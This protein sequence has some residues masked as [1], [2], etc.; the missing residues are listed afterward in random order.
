MAVTLNQRIIATGR[1]VRC[2][3]DAE[4]FG[5]RTTDVDVGDLVYVQSPVALFAVI[6]V[7]NLRNT[8]GYRPIPLLPDLHLP[9]DPT[10]ADLLAAI[11]PEQGVATNDRVLTSISGVAEWRVVNATGIGASQAETDAG[12]N[13]T[14]FV[15][16]KT[17]HGYV[18]PA[19]AAKSPSAYVQSDGA[20]SNRASSIAV[21]GARGNL[22]GFP[23]P[24]TAWALVQ[25][26]AGG[27]YSYLSAQSNALDPLNPSVT[28]NVFVIGVSSNDILIRARGAGSTDTRDFRYTGG[29]TAYEGRLVL[30]EAVWASGDTSADPQIFADGADITASFVASVGAGTPPNWFD[31]GLVGTNHILGQSHP[32]GRAPLGAFGFGAFSAAERAEFVRTGLPPAWWMRGG[33]AVQRITGTDNADFNGGTTGNWATTNATIANVGNALEIT[34]T[35]AFGGARLGNAFAPTVAGRRYGLRFDI[36]SVSAGTVNLGETGFAT[37]YV[38]GLT[39]GTGQFVQFTAV[40]TAGGIAFRLTNNAAVAVIDNLALYEIGG[41]T[42]PAPIRDTLIVADATDLGNVPGRIVGGNVVSSE[43]RTLRTINATTLLTG[44]NQL[45]GGPVFTANNTVRL[46]RWS[47]DNRSGGTRVVSLGSASAGTQY[48]A[49]VTCPVGRTDVI[50][51][52]FTNI[53]QNLWINTDSAGELVHTIAFE[54]P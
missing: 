17:L 35:A 3:G 1:I 32:A 31:S 48:A 2:P 36:V 39:A 53:T 19:L 50:L 9:D 37:N 6:D 22:A 43:P 21:P 42:H 40:G 41:I 45:L 18:N 25:V 47:I 23:G 5:L 29:R 16:P 4:R 52:G 51:N 34:A 12:T 28:S 20:T 46:A 15:A 38:T 11:L 27:I 13:D 54:E 26:G 33:S 10:P 14:K 24:V 49:S 7:T 30:F 8:T 44:N